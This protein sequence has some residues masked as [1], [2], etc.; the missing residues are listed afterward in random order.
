M[1]MVAKAALVLSST[2]LMAQVEGLVVPP[3]AVVAK[4][5]P[6]AAEVERIIARLAVLG[7]REF[8]Y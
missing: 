3:L 6:L 8:S 1:N 2:R 7:T 4:A 5:V